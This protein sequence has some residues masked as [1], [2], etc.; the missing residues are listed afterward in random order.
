MNE[1]TLNAKFE[2]LTA[3]EQKVYLSV[4][5]KEAWKNSTIIG[6]LARKGLPMHPKSVLAI[7]NKLAEQKLVIERP[8]SSWRR[9]TANK[10]F[11]TPDKN[12]QN[13]AGQNQNTQPSPV[14][15]P[16]P[17]TGD[18]QMQMTHVPQENKAVKPRTPVEIVDEL[19]L[20][21]KKF[22]GKAE[23]AALEIAEYIAGVES[24]AK[25]LEKFKELFKEMGA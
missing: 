1:K 18:L 3:L 22:S 5:I 4:P 11:S 9:I 16:E 13:N 19:L 21:L 15:S 2:S 14:P 20:E 12:Q 23:S 17:I 7:L 24:Q 25:K 8:R 6:E 10:P